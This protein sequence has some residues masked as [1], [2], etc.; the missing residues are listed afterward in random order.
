MR[1]YDVVIIGGGVMGA[2]TAYFLAANPDF[3][4]RVALIE[5]DATYARA[6]T[7]LS[8]SSIR[9][10]F[11]T[12]VNIEMSKFGIEFLRRV[13]RTLAVGDHRPRIDL[14][15]GGYLYLATNAGIGDL[16]RN[17]AL[18]RAHGV[19]VSLLT[20]DALARRLPWLAVGDL[21]GGAVTSGGE[22]WFDAYS[23]LTAF[24]S[25]ARALG[26]EEIRAEV[27]SV[28]AGRG[29]DVAGVTLSDGERIGAR[30]VVDA[31]GTAAPALAASVGV[32]LPVVRR[33]RCVFF[34]KCREPIE[35]C[36]MV[37]DPS[38]LWFRPEGAGF[39]AGLPPDPDPDVEADDF[40]VDFD[41]F[42]EC[43]WPLLAARAPRFEAVRRVE[44]WAGHYDYNTADQNALVG[45]AS[46]GAN[47]LV[48]C[49]FSGHG[50]QQAPAVGR[51]LAEW[52]TYGGYRSLDLSDLAC[53]RWLEGRRLTEA[54]II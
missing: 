30:F 31:A 11:S 3:G 32:A 20:P 39:I 49:G 4:G 40:E 22:G 35:G 2:A 25:K 6:A 46:A 9:Q 34:F 47:L 1:S 42:D 52:I 27:A 19:P 15:E 21:A 53:T 24:R 54:N 37:I 12:A 44:A 18:Q 45:P 36:P 7:A 16:E 8:A 48:A 28:I 33:K 50:L 43:I 23:L 5:R 14:H 41:L 26:V 17:V 29:V 38:G 10:Q 51:G 13:D